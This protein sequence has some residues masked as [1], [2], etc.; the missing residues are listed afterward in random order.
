M[1]PGRL[2]PTPISRF[3]IRLLD[4]LG[5]SATLAEFGP[6]AARAVLEATGDCCAIWLRAGREAGLK[7][8]G[9]DHRNSEMVSLIQRLADGWPGT[10][11]SGSWDFTLG[12]REPRLLAVR[13]HEQRLTVLRSQGRAR[14]SEQLGLT[15]F[16]LAPL[17]Y[18]GQQIGV[19]AIGSSCMDGPVDCTNTM[20][21]GMIAE[22]LSATIAH[23]QR[24]ERIRE[25]QRK[26]D[27]AARKELERQK[28]E[29][30]SMIS[31]ELRTPLASIKGSA[32]ILRRIAETRTVQ[33]PAKTEMN[34]LQIMDQQINRM[35]RLVSDL[36]Q[37][38]SVKMGR[39][40]LVKTRFDLAA[41]AASVLSRARS[42]APNQDLRIKASGDTTVEADYELLEQV[43]Y[44]L[45]TN[46][47]KATKAVLSAAKP[48]VE[49]NVRI[50]EASVV[51]SVYDQGVG[52][53]KNIHDLIFQQH[54]RGPERTHEGMG[55]GLYIT[56]GIIEAHGGRIWLESEPG[57]GTTFYFSLPAAGHQ[58]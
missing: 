10:R 35:I 41:L 22:H 26:L 45:I 43:F 58:G 24:S 40:E 42:T 3:L 57:K 56:R 50:S 9:V 25:E 7:L 2:E 52:I 46:G 12:T 48:V 36:M 30:L 15:A 18:E 31:H 51:A 4:A 29:F 33:N 38:S 32:Q 27:L 49:V 5:T 17:A 11:Q 34:M 19:L 44:S 37:F 55:L 20:L 21:A 53:E 23:L 16:L 28:D 1:N 14:I 47:I 54:Y 6:R 13:E 8:A 39:L